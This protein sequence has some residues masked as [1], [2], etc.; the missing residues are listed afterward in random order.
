[1]IDIDLAVFWVFAAVAICS[2]VKVIHSKEIV[3]SLIYLAFLFL[4]IACI[5]ILLS[6]EF[7]ALVQILI[8]VGA[9]LVVILF[10]IM[11][12]KREIVPV[13]EDGCE[14]ESDAE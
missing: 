6:A 14:E 2:A 11:L 5:Y 3:H 12:T 9:V 13:D 7:V 4:S 1:M 8:Y 10:G